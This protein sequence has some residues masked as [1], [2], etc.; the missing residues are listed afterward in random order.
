MEPGTVAYTVLNKRL[1]GRSQSP[2]DLVQREQERRSD[3][4]EQ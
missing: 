1:A 3:R 4:E 2:K